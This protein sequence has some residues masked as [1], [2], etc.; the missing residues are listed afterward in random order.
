MSA[1]GRAGIK[2]RL[3]ALLAV[4][5]DPVD[6]N[7]CAGWFA[8]HGLEPLPG[9][10]LALPWC[11]YGP[12]FDEFWSALQELGALDDT[13]YMAWPALGDYEG[14]RLRIADAPR[15]DLGK[16][17]FAVY[18]QERFVTGLWAGKLHKGELGAAAR[19]ML[20]LID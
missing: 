10:A 4:L 3:A 9:G 15:D 17:L 12:R 13:D 20:S 16:W 14:G 18:R 19:R 11:E 2:A 1:A 6:E 7:G 8:W 5:P